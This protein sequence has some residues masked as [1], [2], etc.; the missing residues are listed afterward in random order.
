IY[1]SSADMLSRNLNRR[2]EVAFPL[3]DQKHM[4]EINTIIQ[5]QLEDNT[6]KRIINSEGNNEQD[7]LNM[8]EPRRAQTEI[9]NWIAEAH[10][11]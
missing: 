3:Y 5:L 1:L 11:E 9:Y 2:I 10:K 6:K 8:E 4:A 7:T